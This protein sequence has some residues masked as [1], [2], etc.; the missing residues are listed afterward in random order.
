MPERPRFL[1]T[2]G[3]TREM[4]DRVRDWGNVFTGN[5]GFMIAQAL[6]RIGDVELLTSNE[7]H[8]QQLCR[9]S[10]PIRAAGFRSYTQLAS[11]L[12][13][14]MTGGR[15]DGVF[16]TAAV[17]D[18][19]PVGVFEIVDRQGGEDGAQVWRVRPVQAG[20]VKSSYRHIAVEGRQTAKLIDRFRGDWGHRGLL[21]KFKL[22]VGI[23]PDDLVHVGQDS[24]RASGADYLVANTLDMVE[25]DKAG[26]FLLSD[27]GQEWVPRAE[28]AVRLAR[29]AEQ[30]VRT[31]PPASN[32]GPPR[33]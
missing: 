26:A 29:L 23:G 2:A 27:A 24:R 10:S 15:H 12:N 32:A 22:E 7:A 18:Y 30:W 33:A 3:S 14:R 5:T 8:L 9:E 20:K 6:T 17:S 11:A 28:L 25:G 31:H 13:T 1:V 19:V 21:V 4:I 16:M